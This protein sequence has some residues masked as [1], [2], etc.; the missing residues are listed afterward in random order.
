MPQP[1]AVAF[2]NA[3]AMKI[4][5]IFARQAAEQRISGTVGKDFG[6]LQRAA[7]FADAALDFGAEVADQALDRPRRGIAERAD[8]VALDLLG[9]VEQSVDLADVG[10]AGA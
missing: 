8:R 2:A 9:H 6:C 4:D 3:A 1:V 5:A 10:V 7:I